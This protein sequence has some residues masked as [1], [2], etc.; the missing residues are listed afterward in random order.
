MDQDQNHSYPQ[1]YAAADNESD[2][3]S[4]SERHVRTDGVSE[5]CTTLQ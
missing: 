5:S 4:Q 2:E 1:T 3:G